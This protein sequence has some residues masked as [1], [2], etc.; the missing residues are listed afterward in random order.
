VASPRE[1]AEYVLNNPLYSLKDPVNHLV[2]SIFR[3]WTLSFRG[4]QLL[5]LPADQV[6][7]KVLFGLAPP[8]PWVLH[9]GFADTIAVESQATKEYCQNE[10]ID[11]QQLIATGSIDNDILYNG[12]AKREELKKRLCQKFNIPFDKPILLSAL[13]PDMLYGQGRSECEFTN[14]NAL[15]QYWIK[16]ITSNKQ[17]SVIVNLHPAA[18]IEE[19][20]GLKKH[21][22]ILTKGE[23][24]R[25]IPL[26]DIFVASIS[27]TIQWAIACGKPVVN[28]DVYKY[29]YTDYQ[30]VSGV[31][32]MESKR[33]F[34]ETLQKLLDNQQ[35]YNM[36]ASQQRAT[37][38]RWG[39]LD[40]KS[41][42]RTL[43][44][45]DNLTAR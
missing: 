2:G 44:L 33:E 21:D 22:L 15:V 4:K 26:C 27:S 45:I 35:F 36:I 12:L 9:C 8:N 28:Y 37:A 43:Q 38:K 17:Y 1:P 19:M 7:A 34:E 5:R 11:S 6:I 16:T 39:I 24:S 32:T 23:I 40:G 42:A 20:Q 14:Y 41:G 3:R 13:P 29:R 25:L 10:G 30:T 18:K 31:L